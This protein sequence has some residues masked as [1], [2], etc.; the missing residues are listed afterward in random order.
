MSFLVEIVAH[1]LLRLPITVLLF[2]A[3][4]VAQAFAGAPVW[5]VALQAVLPFWYLGWPYWTLTSC[6]YFTNTTQ[7]RHRIGTG[8]RAK[9]CG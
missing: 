6:C 7:T 1:P 2:L 3:V 8:F 9:Y 4:V 5:F